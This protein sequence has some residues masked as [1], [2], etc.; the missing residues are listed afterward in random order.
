MRVLLVEPYLGGSHAQWAEGLRRHSGH[1]VVLVGHEGRYWRWRMRGGPVTLAE[2]A[3]EAVAAH[4]RPDLVLV[5]GM[6]DLAAFCGLSRSWL[7]A[8]PVAL[9]LHESQLLHPR[10]PGDGTGVEG[11]FANWRS[12]VAADHVFVATRYH[13][14]AL[15]D[16]SPPRWRRCPT[17]P[18]ATCSSRSR[19]ARR[20]CRSGSS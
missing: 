3:A 17:N 16:A 11:V 20:C 13:R 10:R 4:G 15:L 14:E 5:S 12:M 19:P 1:E 8:T 9:Y 7:G 18:T 6:T 2:R